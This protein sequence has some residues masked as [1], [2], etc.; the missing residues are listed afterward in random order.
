[1]CRQTLLTHIPC[2]NLSI[3]T[4]HMSQKEILHSSATSLMVSLQYVL[5]KTCIFWYHKDI[6]QARH[7]LQMCTHHWSDWTTQKLAY[8]SCTAITRHLYH[9]IN[10]GSHYQELCVQFYTPA[11][12]HTLK[13]C[14]RVN[15][16]GKESLTGTQKHM[17]SDIMHMIYNTIINCLLAMTA[18]NWM[19]VMRY[20]WLKMQ[21][22]V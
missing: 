15:D 22:R 21:K 5:T 7:F 13:H 16:P 19:A 8:V 3:I 12:F 20:H 10:F 1:M 17:H 18:S 4:P 11:L 14:S 2:P 6:Q 9:F